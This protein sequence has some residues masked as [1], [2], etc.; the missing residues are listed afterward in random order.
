MKT[1]EEKLA[2]AIATL[3]ALKA[4]LST[5]DKEYDIVK[6]ALIELHKAEK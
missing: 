1:P 4:S 6:F 5:L 2:Y 3:E